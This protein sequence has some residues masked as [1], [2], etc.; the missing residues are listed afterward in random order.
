MKQAIF[1]FSTAILF[2][3]GCTDLFSQN[4][5]YIINKDNPLLNDTNYCCDRCYCEYDIAHFWLE[6]NGVKRTD[7]LY[8]WHIGGVIFSPDTI[9]YYKENLS[10]LYLNVGEY[11]WVDCIFGGLYST[12]TIDGLLNPNGTGPGIGFSVIQC[13]P[14]ANILHHPTVYC[15]N[16]TIEIQEASRRKPTRWRWYINKDNAGY[17]LYSTDTTFKGYFTD[18]GFY[19]LKLEVENIKGI[20]SAFTSF[21]IIKGVEFISDTIK[22]ITLNNTTETELDAC[23]TAEQ[24]EWFPKEN[25]SCTTCYITSAI[26]NSDAN[27]YCIASNINGCKETCFYNIIAPFDIFVPNAFTPNNDGINDLFKVR[28]VNIEVQSCK[29]YNRLGNEM[30]NGN[31]ETGWNGMFKNEPVETG[32]YAY[33]IIYKN[34]KTNNTER[35][36]GALNLIR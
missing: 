16:S 7:T 23:A 33:T 21:H 9:E 32:V 4:N 27:Y 5:L 11:G 26:V 15:S 8:K 22:T 13:K 28:G 18:T 6:V 17:Y 36:A 3:Y 35:K 2:L 14:I 29:I 19:Q 12:V 1:L 24:Y 10:E 34:L 20:D 25:L 30:Y 31:L